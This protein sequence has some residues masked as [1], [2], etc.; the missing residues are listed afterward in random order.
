MLHHR[1]DK[2][3]EQANKNVLKSNSSEASA[4]QNY[5]DSITL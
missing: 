5:T 4:F 3:T 2:D 1:K